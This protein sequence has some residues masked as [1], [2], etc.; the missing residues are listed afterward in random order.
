MTL[1]EALTQL[2]REY[3]SDRMA[4]AA[5]GITPGQWNKLKNWGRDANVRDETLKKLGLRR[6][7]SFE[8]I[9]NVQKT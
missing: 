5:H 9:D 3:G 2:R 4:A 8:W 7:A 1:H 6:V